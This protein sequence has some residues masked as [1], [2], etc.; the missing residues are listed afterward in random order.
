MR[1]TGAALALTFANTEA[2]QLHLD[3]I[4][5]NVAVGAH[6]VLSFAGWHTTPSLVMPKNIAPIWLSSRA[7]E[8]HPSRTS[9]NIF[10]QTGSRTVSSKPSTESSPASAK[11][12]TNSQLAPKQSL[13][14][15]CGI[16]PTSVAPRA[17]IS[18]SRR[19]GEEGI[20]TQA[21]GRC[22]VAAAQRKSTP[23]RSSF[24]TRLA[25]RGLVG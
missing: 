1:G 9:G 22:A 12:G 21:I 25:A 15:E 18:V 23:T 17:S 13:Q 4:S 20:G 5:A 24:S 19:H 14:S 6:A 10:G 3:E 16:G 11:P 8:L 7:P 2:T